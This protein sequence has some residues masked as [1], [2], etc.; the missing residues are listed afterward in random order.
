MDNGVL[1]FRAAGT[2]PAGGTVLDVPVR[3]VRLEDIQSADAFDA[4]TALFGVSRQTRTGPNVIRYGRGPG[5]TRRFSVELPSGGT[6][7]EALNG[8]VRTHGTLAWAVERQ[9]SQVW[10]ELTFGP[11]GIG[12]GTTRNSVVRTRA[13]VMHGLHPGSRPPL[14]RV[15]GAFASARP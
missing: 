10:V 3:A 7:R 2:W 13:V 14:E 9:A 1:L 6:L 5:D 12:A 11:G 8:I 4:I 15:V